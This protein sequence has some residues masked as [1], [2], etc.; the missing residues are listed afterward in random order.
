M[1][2][3]K[4]SLVLEPVEKSELKVGDCYVYIDDSGKWQL[5]EYSSDVGIAGGKRKRYRLPKVKD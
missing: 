4:N 5:N 3:H 2:K 1:E